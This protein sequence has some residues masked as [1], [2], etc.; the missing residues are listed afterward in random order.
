[1]NTQNDNKDDLLPCPF[2]LSKAKRVNGIYVKDVECTVCKAIAPTAI[3]NNRS[4]PPADSE[5]V[6]KVA[7][8]I[9]SESGGGTPYEVFERMAKAAIAALSNGSAT[10]H[11]GESTEMVGSAP[12]FL[13]AHFAESNLIGV[14]AN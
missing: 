7:K 2:C 14:L 3:W 10:N 6:E 9:R 12:I 13:R 8:A 5:M 1:M 11:I 4:K